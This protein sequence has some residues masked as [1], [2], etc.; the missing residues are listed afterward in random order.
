LNFQLSAVP[1]GAA[2][3]AGCGHKRQI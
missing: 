1:C 3:V 2:G